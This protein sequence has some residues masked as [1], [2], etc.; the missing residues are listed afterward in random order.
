MGMD[1]VFVGFG[2]FKSFNLLKMVKV[3]V[4]VVNYWDEFDVFVEISKEIGELMC[5]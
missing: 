1:G 4:E 2:I 3:I 5:G